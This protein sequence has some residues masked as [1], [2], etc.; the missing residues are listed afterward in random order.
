M[1]EIDPESSIPPSDSNKI[2]KKIM[3][4]PYCAK[5]GFDKEVIQSRLQW[6]D[7][8]E[9][10][11]TIA[12]QIH[13]D[14]IV[15]NAQVII[16]AF[17]SYLLNIDE[18]KRWLTDSVTIE[19]LKKTQLSYLL[20]LGI[21]FT[22]L[23]YFEARLRIGQAHAWAGLNL[24][25]Y[26][27]AYSLLT[28]LIVERI[29]PEV[30][31]EHFHQLCSFIH[32][33]TSLDMSLAIE[34]Y[35][36][37]QVRSLEE[38]LG[39]AQIMENQL[40]IEASTDKL[41]GFLNHEYILNRLRQTIEDDVKA[42]RP[43]S[44]MMADL[45]HFKQ[46]ND[47]YGHLVG[48]KVLM[49]VARRLD[50]AVR[51]FDILGRYGGEEFLIVLK[52]TPLSTALAVA[53]RVRTHVAAGPVSLHGGLKINSTISIGVSVRRPDDSVDDFIRRADEALYAAKSAGRNCV[54][55]AD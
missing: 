31:N 55:S 13:E 37:S 52:G 38:S 51:D 32:K 46:V 48:D 4:Y 27:C 44:L 9:K 1:N 35:H 54:R 10:D 5:F 19:R 18:A 36:F 33:I 25:L 50:A 7:L 49:E 11:L 22:K 14:I 8:G 2:I 41:T 39:R 12:E 42:N 3:S 21:D 24:S 15:P 34:T 20:T 29:P 26:Q 30:D 45:D 17:Y 47:T 6:L 23:D 53:D 28:E 40:R 43:T 16:D